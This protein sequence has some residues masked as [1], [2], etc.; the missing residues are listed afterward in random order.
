MDE[1]EKMI[2]EDRKKGRLPF[3]VVGTAGSTRAGTVD[4]LNDIA[5]VCARENLTFHVD[6]AW[7]GAAV[8][9]DNLR[10]ELQ[11]IEKSDTITFDPHKWLSVPMACGVVFTR[12]PNAFHSAFGVDADYVPQ[13]TQGEI[14]WYQ[15]S[16]QWSRRFIGFK[17]FLSPSGTQ[18]RREWFQRGTLH[19]V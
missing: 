14:D 17:L 4:P 3:L 16:P 1:L 9:S 6:A 19:M 12:D 15:N 7:G 11:G 10:G 13:G 5:S 2:R 18:L 8:L